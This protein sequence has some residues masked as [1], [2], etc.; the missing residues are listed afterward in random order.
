M[1]DQC[2]LRCAQCCS[3]SPHLP[4]RMTSP[5][6]LERDLGRAAKVLSPQTFKL[7]GGEPFLHPG[8]AELLEVARSAGIS[9]QIS[10]TTNGFLAASA[11]DAV[12]ERLDR[13]TVSLYSSAP[14]P[15]STLD[16]L[17]A[18]CREHGVV[19]NEKAFESFQRITPEEEDPGRS[20]SSWASCWMK[21]RCHLVHQGR[22]FTCTRPPH[23][24]AWL[25]TTELSEADGVSLDAPELLGEVLRYLGRETPLRSCARCLGNSGELRPH[26]QLKVVA[27]PSRPAART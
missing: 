26:T 3:L 20:E 19:L 25:G 15:M 27:V 13:M 1:V 18:R 14:L 17:R 12:Y 7:S 21:T 4:A 24:D 8:L 5:A 10:V 22:F 9:R 11:K 23:T 6:E 2:N 16:R